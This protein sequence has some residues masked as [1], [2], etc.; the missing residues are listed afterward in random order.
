MRFFSDVRLTYARAVRAVLREPS[1]III[2]L[3]QPLFY[4]YLVSRA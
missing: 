4:L 3:A 2:G 1:W